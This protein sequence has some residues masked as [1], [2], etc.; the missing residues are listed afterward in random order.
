MGRAHYLLGSINSLMGMYSE[1][2]QHYLEGMAILQELGSN[3]S[4]ALGLWM[5]SRDRFRQKDVEK[6]KQLMHEAIHLCLELGNYPIAGEM[7]VTLQYF[8]WENGDFGEI[9]QLVDEI[10]PIVRRTQLP[11]RYVFEGNG[12]EY[13][14]R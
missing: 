2:E 7:Y 6:G 13:T 4:F 10:Q 14:D 3:F 1:A 9:N 5:R 11:Q 8:C 12:E